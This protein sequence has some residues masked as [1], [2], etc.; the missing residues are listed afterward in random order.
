[1][2]WWLWLLLVSLVFLLAAT[3]A[4]LHLRRDPFARSTLAALQRLGWRQRFEVA[5]AIAGDR[6]VPRL[7]RWLPLAL[8]AY[9]AFPLDVIP[10]FIPVLGQLDDLIAVAV[11]LWLLTRLVPHAVVEEH[12]ARAAA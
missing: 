11:V 3:A 5:R 9:L 12:L 1:V 8:A 6:R 7:A 4:A 2:P 10:D